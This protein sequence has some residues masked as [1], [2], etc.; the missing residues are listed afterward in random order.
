MLE[1]E[2]YIEQAYFF[3]VLGERLLES[4]PTQDVLQLIREEILATTKLPM[5]IDYLLSE[6]RHGGGFAPAMVRLGHYFTPFQSYV[7]QEAEDERGRFDMRIALEILKREVQ[8]R[9]D[10]AAPQGL[11][12][13]Q[14][15]A[16]CRNRLGYDR[17]L[18]AMAADPVFDAAWR[19]WI[20]QVRHQ[21]G[22]LD[23]ADLI[24]IKSQY[25][26]IVQAQQGRSAEGCEPLFGERE[27]RIALANRR[28]DPVYL[29]NSL[30]RQLG[31]PAV[32][33]PQPVDQ[34]R[35]LVPLLARRMERLE[36]RLQLLE[37]ERRG[38]IDLTQFYRPPD[39]PP[40]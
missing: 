30:H 15:E 32:P 9:A 11:F 13:Y 19:A 17:G 1:R 7:I 38:G 21:V 18:E 12:L 3:R 16:L 27:G 10:G 36:S 34:T 35:D 26:P 33:R 25:Y 28:K 23:M 37:E 14:F 31:Y 8:Y 29:F 20:L 6:L 4:V 2:E 5:A 24:Y 39:R 22:I 40:E